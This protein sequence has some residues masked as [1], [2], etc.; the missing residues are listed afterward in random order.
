[1]SACPVNCSPQEFIC[2]AKENR[3][4][5]AV[6]SICKNN[7]MGHTCGLICPDNF[8][9]KACLRGKIDHPI[10]IPQ[11]QAFLIQRYRA[12]MKVDVPPSPNGLKIAVIGAGPAGMAATWVL[13]K[14]GFEVHIFE[15][16]DRVGGA[17]NLIPDYRLPFEAIADDWNFI[18]KFGHAEVSF[19]TP[20][21][22]PQE[23]VNQGFDG[24][25]VAVGEQQGIDLGIEGVENV[26]PY[27]E[28]LNAPETYV[29]TGNVAIIGGGNV[30]ADCAVTAKN[31]GA[32]N[33][34]MFVRRKIFDM[35]VTRREMRELLDKQIDLVTTTRICKVER[36]KQGF[37]LYTCSTVLGEHGYE[38][39]ANSQ[40]CRKGFDV[41]IK[42]IGSRAVKAKPCDNIIYA[43]DCKTG[44][45]TI[46]EAVASG[47][48]AAKLLNNKIMK[49]KQQ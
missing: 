3:P 39:I 36:T 44:G 8:C 14:E 47:L 32:K 46:V 31:I 40:I 17:L 10:N 6:R 2:H 4:F 25:I 24:I 18:Q 48:E 21:D 26:I 22:K 37:N 15:K 1:M 23:L 19:N 41:V 12:E 20:I 13:L 33:V 34:S 45:S 28:Y 16:S 27:A 30:A 9:L 43:G 49:G 5:D 29:T 38:D 35:K 11:V 42:A 7:P